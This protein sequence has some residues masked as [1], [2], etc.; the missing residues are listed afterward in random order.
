MPADRIA[1]L[2]AQNQELTEFLAQMA[3]IY[4]SSDTNIE[5]VMTQ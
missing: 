2:E 5:G 4:D 3:Q 1:E